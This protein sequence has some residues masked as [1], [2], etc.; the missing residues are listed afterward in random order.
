MWSGLLI[1]IVMQSIFFTL[2]L[3]KLNW[4]KATKEVSNYFNKYGAI[5]YVD[6]TVQIQQC[7][8]SLFLVVSISLKRHW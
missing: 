2:F 1:S 3:W 6:T 4:K 8:C 5:A 7:G